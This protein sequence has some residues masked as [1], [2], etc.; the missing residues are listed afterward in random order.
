MKSLLGSVTLALSLSCH[1]ATL[2][3]TA[4]TAGAAAAPSPAGSVAH[5]A[6]AARAT[7]TEHKGWGEVDAIVRR[8]TP[9]SFA[10]RNC[11]I[12]A[13]GAV[14]GGKEDA[15]PA[16]SRAIAECSSKGGGHVLIPPGV[17]LTGAIHLESNIDLHLA[18]GATL[19]FNPDPAAYLPVVLTRWEGI[20]C[21]NYSPLIY[22]HG[23]E[24]IAITGKGTLDGA[25]G[26]D[27]WWR[28]A[29]KAPGQKSMAADDVAALNRMSEAGV[30]VEQRVFGAGHYLR[31]NFIQVYSSKNV[32]IE[33]VKIVRSPMWEIHPVL[34]E[35]VTVRGVEIVSHGP[36]NDGCNP[37]SSRDVLIENCV[38]D[39]GDDCI[40]IKSGRNEDGRRVGRRVEN[41]IVRGSTMRDGHAG[42]AIGSEISGGAHNIFI[43]NNRMDSPNLDR[44]LR[45]KSNARRG[46]VIENVFMRN[47]LVGR[48]SEALLT[49]DFLYEEGPRGDFPP[50]ARNIVIEN[51]KARQSPRLFYIAGFEAATIDGIH[52]RNTQIENATATEVIEHAGSIELDNVTLTPAIRPRS[53][54]SRPPVGD[55]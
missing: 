30:P 33:G 36:N 19:R 6:A 39:V 22:A 53:L 40:A 20:E 54:S 14:A 29:K 24:N 47:V 4:P 41:I 31:P 16:I 17:F 55:Q 48:V 7:E 5:P 34:S 46:G 26:E 28:W 21:M 23:K 42:V 38:F 9:P 25:A 52:V 15:S 13:Y 49:I 3:S 27:N 43:E 35:N 12:T 18:E 32:L 50:T 45:L 11:D 37:D 44:A 10:E 8:I 51:V 2:T 1:S